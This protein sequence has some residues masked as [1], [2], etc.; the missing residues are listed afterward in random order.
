MTLTLIISNV[1]IAVAMEAQ[2]ELILDKAKV[3]E[4]ALQQNSEMLKLRKEVEIAETSLSEVRANFSPQLSVN[5]IYTRMGEAPKQ[6]LNNYT[7][8]V[9]LQQ[10]LFMGGQLKAGY[11]QAGK[12]YQIAKLEFEQKKAELK[13]SLLK[14]YYNILKAKKMV[15][16]S[17]QNVA[18]INRY[19]EIAQVNKE[20]GIFTN[21]DVLQAKINANRAEQG[22]LKA[23]NAFKLAKLALKNSLGL[24]ADQAIEFS[25]ELE[26]SEIELT[27]SE[28]ISYALMYRPDLKILE[29]SEDTLSLNIKRT[30]GSRYPSLMLNGEYSTNGDKLK[31]DDGKWNLSLLLSF[32]L[33]DGGAK[34]SKIKKAEKELE[35]FELTKNQAIDGVKLEIKQSLLTLEEA[36]Q[37]IELMRL[38][39]EEA[40]NNLRDTEIKFREGI[41]TSFD[42]LNAQTTLQQ[43]QNDYYQAI[44]DYNL[45]LISLERAMGKAVN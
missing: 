32:D 23:R 2:T 44:Y 36:K 18:Q 42:V 40:K 19:V 1:T 45:A 35:K 5:T 25:D 16:L 8:K 33:Y 4:L 29:L 12:N 26:W 30:K 21:T 20:V 39:L 15:K 43:V 37:S 6:S 17:Q 31:I 10:P 41:V 24:R 9:G 11:N 22:L 27:E 38:S 14:Q 28:A 13:E 7:F 34:D 3:I